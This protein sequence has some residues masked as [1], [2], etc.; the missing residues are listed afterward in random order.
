M[1]A[2]R[3]GLEPTTKGL[4]VPCSTAE[5]PARIPCSVYR[6]TLL[7]PDHRPERKHPKGHNQDNQQKNRSTKP[8]RLLTAISMTPP[9]THTKNPTN[10]VPI[11]T[12]G[13]RFTGRP[14]IRSDR[15][16]SPKSPSTDRPAEISTARVNDTCVP[17]QSPISAAEGRYGRSARPHRRTQRPRPRQSRREP[18]NRLTQTTSPTPLGA[19]SGAH[20]VVARS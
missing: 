18:A 7:E 17:S 3:V 5:L 8:H 15:A 19:R 6:T 1:L 14:R 9:N 4:K 12:K 10:P 20:H 11:A 16:K 2:S 13:H